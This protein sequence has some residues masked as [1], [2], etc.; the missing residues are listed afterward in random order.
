MKGLQNNRE[1]KGDQIQA[2]ENC[3]EESKSIPV[4]KFNSFHN[5]QNSEPTIESLDKSA[6]IFD[7]REV[8]LISSDEGNSMVNINDLD[9]HLDKMIEKNGG[10]WECKVCGKTTRKKGDTKK[11]AETHIEGISHT[12]Q[13][14]SKLFSTRD[15]LQVHTRKIHSVKKMLM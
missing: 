11:H 4:D 1:D 15:S 3:F 8:A 2:G 12:R 13:I 7:T 6:D 14:C 5:P 10:L 9:L